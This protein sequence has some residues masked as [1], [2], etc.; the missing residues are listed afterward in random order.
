MNGQHGQNIESYVKL[1]EQKR[2]DLNVSQFIRDAKLLTAMAPDQD[3][4]SNHWQG[5]G[6]FT[7]QGAIRNGKLGTLSESPLHPDFID[8]AKAYIRH[9]ESDTPSRHNRK[10]DLRALRLVEKSLTQAG[11]NP[12]PC[13]ISLHVLNQAAEMCSQIS[14]SKG[15][16]Y[17]TGRALQQLASLLH[18]KSLTD[19]SVA[20]FSNP[21]AAPRQLH[22]KLGNEANEHRKRSL[23]DEDSISAIASIFAKGFDLANPK[24]HTDIY[25]TSCIVL[26]LAGSKRGGEIHEME[27]DA[28]IEEP[29]SDGNLQYGW[30]FRSFK[31][32]KNASRI[33]WCIKAMEPHA[34]EAFH[35]LQEITREGREFAKYAEDQLALRAASPNAP[36]RFYRHANCPNVL[37]DKPLSP[38]EV[39]NALGSQCTTEK[40]AKAILKQ[41]GLSTCHGNHTLNSLWLWAL[42]RLPKG[43]PY[44]K[45]AKN[46]RLKY[47]RMLFCMHPFQLKR[48]A[49]IN[50]LSVWS[51]SLG[52]L[53][54]RLTGSETLPSIFEYHGANAADGTP[55]RL[56]SHQIRHLLD[57]LAHEGTG[58]AFLET[59]FINQMAGRAKSWQGRTYD[60]SKPED[61]AEFVRNALEQAGFETAVIS[62]PGATNTKPVATQ[63][64]SVRLKPRS[65]A[66]LDISFRSAVVSTLY[67]SCEHD[68][69]LQP[70]Q[71]QRDC[72]NCHEHFCIKGAGKDDQER[73]HRLEQL[74]L[75]VIRQQSLAQTSATK[76]EYGAKHW[77]DFQTAYRQR[78]EELIRLLKDPQVENGAEIRLERPK[79]NTHLHRVLQQ[80]AVH[81]IDQTLEEQ[82][83][84]NSLLTAFRENRALELKNTTS[85]LQGDIHG[86]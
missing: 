31:S 65:V 62:L 14:K 79:A 81:A 15:S 64:W 59:S 24:T 1:I 32:K 12:Y 84:I 86:T 49:T 28:E 16:Q 20:S 47:S 42:S 18:Q 50:P 26:L 77:F 22:L 36:L 25:V 9:R 72:L 21:I 68:W 76:G 58:D 61:K 53:R 54:D 83:A 82:P 70:C 69:L 10:I 37:D 52:S 60:H 38:L 13:N 41:K 29:D 63:H 27:I 67:G 33:A 46:K 75:K 66:D 17:N 78:V 56:K 7:T 23:P 85:P 48:D 19:Y 3:W 2:A 73:L 44:V 40:N 51:P 39:A 4:E 71:N 34:R 45:G 43:F 57:K 55:L 6:T 30:R 35:R 74:L 8:F 80:K 11:I 5:I